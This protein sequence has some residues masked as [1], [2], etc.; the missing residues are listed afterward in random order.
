MKK[1][2]PAGRIA[3]YFLRSKLT[4]LMILSRFLA[5]CERHQHV[6][7]DR[8]GVGNGLDSSYRRSVQI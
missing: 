8:T 7:R 3:A 4:P 1:L 2:G 6:A 5:C